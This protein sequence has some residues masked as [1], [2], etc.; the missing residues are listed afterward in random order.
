MNHNKTLYTLIKRTSFLL[1]EDERLLLEQFD[2]SVARFNL[3]YHV[4]EKPG[5][6]PS[7]LSDKLLCHRSNITRLV[8]GMEKGGLIIRKRNLADNR[9]VHLS[10]TT[11]GEMLY[12][13]AQASYE[14][15]LTDCMRQLSSDRKQLLI[16]NLESLFQ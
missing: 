12:E 11:K 9:T 2:L 4:Y 7:A 16:E 8:R 1:D 6:G 13:K 15:N 3:L 5:I 10:L 14:A